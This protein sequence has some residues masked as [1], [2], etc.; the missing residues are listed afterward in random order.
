MS[1]QEF[2]PPRPK[3]KPIIYAYSDSRFPG[4]LKIGYTERPIEIRMKEHYPTLTPGES[5]KVE[6]IE[7]AIRND[8][9]V[10]M[11]H[12]VHNV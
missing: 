8:G 7:S 5:W 2:F 9:S 6:Y 11:D 3:S 1:K 10:F 12:E 4:M